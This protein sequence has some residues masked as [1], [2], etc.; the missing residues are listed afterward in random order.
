MGEKI[1]AAGPFIGELGWELMG[2]SGIVRYLKNQDVYKDHKFLVMTHQS[3]YPIYHDFADQ[4]VPLPSWFTNAGYE[5]A[6]Y[7][8]IGLHPLIY[9]DLIKYFRRFYPDNLDELYELRPPRGHNT[10]FRLLHPHAWRRLASSKLGKD[11][12]ESI[13]GKD[14]N[15]KLFVVMPRYRVGVHQGGNSEFNDAR[16]WHPLYWQ[17][18]IARLS[19]DGHILVIAGTKN[20][21]PPINYNIPGVIN[22]SNLDSAYLMDATLAFMEIATGTICSVSGGTHLSV[23]AAC[24]T[25][26]LGHERYRHTIECNPLE[27]PCMFL[28]AGLPYSNVNVEQAYSSVSDFIELISERVHTDRMEFIRKDIEHIEKGLP[29]YV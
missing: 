8:A 2:F 13:I 21:I 28:E 14:L 29:D 10:D 18:L 24:P 4:I 25:W 7:D 12:R 6:S 27:T 23:Q 1:V 16:N 11:I 3:R 9:G 19:N 17:E 26:I 5:S 22:L 15:R 20:G